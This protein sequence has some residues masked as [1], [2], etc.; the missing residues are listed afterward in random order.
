[1]TQ[2]FILAACAEMLWQDK[3]IDWRC[4]RLAE[5]GF[6]VGLWHWQPHDLAKLEFD[7]RNLHHH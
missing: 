5:M 4:A 7:R 3:P 6:Q 1:M 2:P